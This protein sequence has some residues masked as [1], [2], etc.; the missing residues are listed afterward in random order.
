MEPYKNLSGKSGI[1]YYKIGDDHIWVQFFN[2]KYRNYRYSNAS[3]GA[4]NIAQMKQLASDGQG[5]NSF[6]VKNPYVRDG[7]DRR[8]P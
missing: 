6:I 1:A 4:D 7:W 5:L 8:E 3:A 2:G